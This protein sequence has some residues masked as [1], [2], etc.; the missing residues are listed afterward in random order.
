[1]VSII[2]RVLLLFLVAASL[3]PCL[4]RAAK[5]EGLQKELASVSR[6]YET[7]EYEAALELIGRARALP[8]TPGEEVSLLLYEGILWLELRKGTQ[9]RAAFASALELDREARL[10][11]PVSP[12]IQAVFDS[13]RSQMP[14]RAL[15]PPTATK[16]SARGGDV[17]RREIPP[18][19]T[20]APAALVPPVPDRGAGAGGLRRYSLLPAIAGGVFVV[21]G[22]VGWAFSRQ[23]LGRLRAEPPV[24]TTSE[25]AR[26]GAARGRTLQTAGVTL[27]GAGLVGLS[28]AAGMYV[29]GG[30]RQTIALGVGPQGA[31]AFV[32]GEWP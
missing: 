6:L 17:P 7:L 32:G 25:E 29:F 31:S 4:A 30:P 23:E 16:D 27:L 21:A 20:E 10:P 12:K 18:P 13:A 22:G 3:C 5:P 24:Y 9:G 14:P 26:E 19:V 2:Q 28:A 11:V 1:M 8:H 15:P